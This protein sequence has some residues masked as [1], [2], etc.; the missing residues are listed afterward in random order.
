ML[1]V[2]GGN[3]V[4]MLE[5][6]TSNLWEI[7]LSVSPTVVRTFF[8][9]LSGLILSYKVAPHLRPCSR[10]MPLLASGVRIGEY[11][12]IGGIF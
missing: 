4:I 9:N 2:N 1:S 6:A 5:N 3:C 11:H 12:F 7:S 8:L 10:M